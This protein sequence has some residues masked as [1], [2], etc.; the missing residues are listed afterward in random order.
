MLSIL[1]GWLVAFCLT[2]A[3]E[4]P[5]YWRIT[6]SW[7]VA[8]FASAMTHPVVWFCFPWLSMLE[9]PWPVVVGLAEAFA[10]IVEALWLR[11]NGVPRA[12]L[13]SFLANAFSA[14][15]GLVLR[16]LTGWV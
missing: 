6:G 13:W 4:M 12:L 14:T 11:A 5:I 8:F 16:E 15:T 2:Q 9:V 7:R 1:R 3:L 10:V